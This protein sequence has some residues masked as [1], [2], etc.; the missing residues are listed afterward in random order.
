MTGAAGGIGAAAVRSLAGHGMRVYA[1]VR[2]DDETSR[3][4]AKIAN[5]RLITMDVS[6]PASVEAA[7]ETIRR[8]SPALRA[9]VNNAG[10]IVQGPLE[11]VPPAELRRQFE[12]NTFGPAYVVQAFLPLLRAGGGRIV[13][14]GAPTGRVAMPFLGPI[15]ASKAA[16]ESFSN[17]LR[18]ELAAWNIPV[19]VIEPGSTQTRIFDKAGSAEKA[20]RRLSDPQRVRL[21]AD[22]LARMD[23]AQAAMK[24]DPVQPVADAIVHAVIARTPKRRYVVGGARAIGLLLKMP[25]GLRERLL[26]SSLGLRGVAAGR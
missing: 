9:V 26:M 24:Q 6:E 10:V 22:H 2:G 25:T 12:V 23:K 1:T 16:L 11:L 13:N 15:S 21:Y 8:E 20:A 18:L 19:S 17:A 4:L 7:V 14:V 5:V 3:S